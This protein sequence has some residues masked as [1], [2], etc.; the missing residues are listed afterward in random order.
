MKSLVFAPKEALEVRR[1]TIAQPPPQALI[2][3]GWGPRL[4]A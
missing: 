3:A 1:P 4:T 2:F